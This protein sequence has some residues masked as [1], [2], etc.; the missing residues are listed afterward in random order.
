MNNNRNL[1]QNNVGLTV[2]TEFLQ[3]GLLRNFVTSEKLY[4]DI[5][6]SSFFELGKETS[7]IFQEMLL[8]VLEFRIAQ[9]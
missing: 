2:K 6:I 1:V 3:N 8:G 9:I 4:E 7:D 5:Y